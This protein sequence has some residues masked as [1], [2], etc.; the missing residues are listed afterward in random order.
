MRRALF[1]R[2]AVQAMYFG[3]LAFLLLGVW[4]LACFGWAENPYPWYMILLAAC[5]AWNI[6]F[7]FLSLGSEADSELG[8]VLAQQES[9]PVRKI[10]RYCSR[11]SK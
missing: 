9:V 5:G 6:A 3:F 11:S 2:I 8:M 1:L 4:I 10:T 7:V